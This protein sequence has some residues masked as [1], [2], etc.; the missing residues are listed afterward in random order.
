MARRTYSRAN[1]RK[2]G[3]QFGD[4]KQYHEAGY[5][6]KLDVSK[7]DY[8]EILNARLDDHDSDDEADDEFTKLF[9][10]LTSQLRVTAN[11]VSAGPSSASKAY[12]RD[13]LVKLKQQWAQAFREGGRRKLALDV[14]TEEIE[15]RLRAKGALQPADLTWAAQ[16]MEDL[17][18]AMEEC[19]T[20]SVISGNLS[21]DK[22]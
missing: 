10:L 7:E 12:A 4:L 16:A 15:T 6:E 19:V 22:R 14:V 1:K 20:Q 8:Q 21:L 5:A 9:D 18:T 13:D 2:F 11:K 3:K 17:L